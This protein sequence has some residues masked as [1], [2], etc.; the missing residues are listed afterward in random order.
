MCFSL[1]SWKRMRNHLCWWKLRGFLL[2]V[3]NCKWPAEPLFMAKLPPLPRSV[4]FLYKKMHGWIMFG[5]QIRIY[6]QISQVW[7]PL[8]TVNAADSQLWDLSFTCDHR[9]CRCG[10]CMF[11]PRLCVS[12]LVPKDVNWLQYITL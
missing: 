9:F 7:V 8:Y 1:L 2:Y 4:L 10:A 3:S 5:V 12:F 6:V 11:S